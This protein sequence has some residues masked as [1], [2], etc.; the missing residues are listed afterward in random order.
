MHH[1]STRSEIMCPPD[2]VA[3][4]TLLVQTTQEVA[5]DAIIEQIL[6]LTCG[7]MDSFGVRPYSSCH[8][9]HS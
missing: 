5:L 1:L 8:V 9:T 4:E 6:A 2:K 7:L 3:W